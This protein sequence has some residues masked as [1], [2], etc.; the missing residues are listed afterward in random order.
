MISNNAME[1]EQSNPEPTP[2]ESTTVAA[3]DDEECVSNPISVPKGKRRNS[4]LAGNCSQN[5]QNSRTTKRNGGFGIT[6][7][8]ALV[9]RSGRRPDQVDSEPPAVPGQSTGC[10]STKS[11]TNPSA[12]HLCVNSESKKAL[13]P[14]R[15]TAALIKTIDGMHIFNVEVEERVTQ[16]FRDIQ[17]SL[18]EV[19]IEHLS[20]KRVE[21]RPLGMQLMV[22]GTDVAH[23][24]PYIVFICPRNVESK[25]RSFLQ[26]EFVKIICEGP[27]FCQV[28]FD[29]AVLGRPLRPSAG[30]KLDEVFIREA[31][32]NAV[33]VGVSQIRIVQL[34]QPH[35]GT[36]G[37][38]ISVIGPNTQ[39]LTYG[40]TAGHVLSTAP[41]YDQE[42][43]MSDAE[44]DDSSDELD[45]DIDEFLST[46]S[47][48]RNVIE[49]AEEDTSEL[50]VGERHV[51]DDDQYWVCIGSLAE[52]SYS[53]A[54]RDHDWALVK[55]SDHFGADALSPSHSHTGFYEIAQPKGGQAVAVGSQLH[56]TYCTISK[57]P[58][59]ALLPS[60]RKFVDVHTLRLANN[61]TLPNGSS[62]SWMVQ[63]GPNDSVIVC[64]MIVATDPFGCHWM[65]AMPGILEGVQRECNA[66]RVQLR[67]LEGLQDLLRASAEQK[68]Q[69]ST[70]P[71]KPPAPPML[72]SEPTSKVS[73][74]VSPS[75][76]V[77][78][79]KP[80]GESNISRQYRWR[81]HQCRADNSCALN[82]TCVKY[83]T[84][85]H[86]CGHKFQGCS[87]CYIYEV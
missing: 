44:S 22:L 2:P 72:E 53:A 6:S 13:P 41:M 58:A 33:E 1:I 76:P 57:L 17:G 35:Y 16:R 12:P 70:E 32:A 86:V 71:P 23:A 43:A 24:K 36:M 68:P 60:G 4:Q 34:G 40:L 75:A 73:S 55:L 78:Q 83:N 85:G 69:S 19:V 10:V 65:V 82:P 39:R 30:E 42:D 67:E 18:E 27:E 37:G 80:T 26:K 59:R 48:I 50:D 31:D 56:L 64:G 11:T 62:G 9:S 15:T 66:T 61:Q 81:C 79:P 45:P 5:S 77:R 7:I 3:N 52:A 20:R 51:G 28:K 49:L 84:L 47:D 25:L 38:L 74:F 21:F 14:S 8:K 63:T 87:Y 54:A 29:T 46:I